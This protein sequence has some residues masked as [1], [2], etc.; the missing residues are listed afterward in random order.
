MN[1]LLERDPLETAHSDCD[2]CTAIDVRY[3]CLSGTRQYED[4][5]FCLGP[6]RFLV[7]LSTS[8]SKSIFR[9]V[10]EYRLVKEFMVLCLL[11]AMGLN[12]LGW[13][14][15]KPWGD[16]E[17]ERGERGKSGLYSVTQH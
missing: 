10:G 12:R 17:R 9:S 4:G 5:G 13:F 3:C 7:A 14:W 8:K 15:K 16:F 6:I 2:S 11:T 1:K